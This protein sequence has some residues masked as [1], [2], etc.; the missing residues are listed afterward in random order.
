MSRGFQKCKFG[1][2]ESP[3]MSKLLVFRKS[4]MTAMNDVTDIYIIEKV[5]Y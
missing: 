5:N 3:L 2:G 1:A 4:N